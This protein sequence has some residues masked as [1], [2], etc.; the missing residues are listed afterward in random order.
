MEGWIKVY[1]K[2]LDWQWINKPEMVSIF[3]Y[4]LLKANHKGNYFENIEVC[5]GQFITSPEKISIKLGISYQTVRTCLNKLEKSK[6]INKQ[7]TN[8]FTII[9]ICNYE[10][11]QSNEQTNNNETNK[12]LTNNQQSTNKQLTTNNNDNNINKVNN[13]KEIRNNNFDFDFCEIEYLDLLEKWI[14]YKLEKKQR[15]TQMQIEAFYSN[16]IKFSENDLSNAELIINKSISAGYSDIFAIDFKKESK[17]QSFPTIEELD[18]YERTH[19]NPFKTV[20][21]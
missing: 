7:T 9:T 5:R 21:N 19:P 20:K 14:K 15:L 16:L 12:Q 1:R 17:K 4:C 11:Y 13:E 10:S 6:E 18:E 3:L 8:K 2:L